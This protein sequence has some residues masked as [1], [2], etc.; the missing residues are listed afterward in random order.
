MKFVFLSD[1]HLSWDNP[2]GRLDNVKEAEF[3]KLKFVFDYARK[4]H[5]TILQAGDFFDIPRSWLLLPETVNFLRSYSEVEVLSVFGQHDTYMYSEVTKQATNLGILDKGQHVKILSQKPCIWNHSKDGC[6]HIYGC[7]WGQEIPKVKKTDCLNILVIHAPIAEKALW[8]GHE[9][10]NAEKF[11]EE[12]KDFDIILCGDIHMEFLIEKNNRYILNTGPLVRRSATEYN[13]SRE[14]C[15]YVY[16]IK[17][18]KIDR[19]V[20]PHKN[21]EDVLSRSHIERKKEIKIVLDGFVSAIK[22]D[23]E[24]SVDLSENIRKYL[25]KNSI[26]QEIKNII[27]KTMSKKG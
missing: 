14:P 17:K 25:D 18:E 27:A 22:D 24:A 23:L 12:N 9:Y 19:V 2:V 3:E 16:D 21:A 7:S 5:A 13:F 8:H 4:N 10:L 6:Y 11:L 20:I 15:F 1:L 26:S